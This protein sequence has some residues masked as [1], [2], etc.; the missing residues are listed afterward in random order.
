[1]NKVFIDGIVSVPQTRKAGDKEIL[2]LRISVYSGKDKD[3]KS[4]YEFYTVEKW[5]TQ[6][7]TI[8]ADKSRIVVEGRLAT[9]HWT[10]DGQERAAI[11][12]MADSIAIIAPKEMTSVAP[13]ARPH[14]H[15][16]SRNLSM[17]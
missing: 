2:N 10:K 14:S 3:G 1:M 5:M 13:P 17:R 6:Y 4:V 15:R 8:P 16:Q 7:D 11:K 9:D 12:I